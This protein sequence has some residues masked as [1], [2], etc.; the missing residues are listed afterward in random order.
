MLVILPQKLFVES[1]PDEQIT[2]AILLQQ[3]LTG[4]LPAM[5]RQLLLKGKPTLLERAV[6]DVGDINF[7]F[8]PHKMSSKMLMLFFTKLYPPPPPMHRS[9]TVCFRTS[10]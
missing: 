7:A 10:D 9:Y 2:S 8:E 6:A 3:F 4:L 5:S 1:Y